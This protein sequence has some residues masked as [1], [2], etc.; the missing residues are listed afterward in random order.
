MS[1]RD[2]FSVRSILYMFVC[3][4]GVGALSGCTA[5]TGQ[6]TRGKKHTLYHLKM[7]QTTGAFVSFQKFRGK[8]VLVDFF[9][10]SC[11]RCEIVVIPMLKKLHTQYEV[12]GLRIV[13]IAIQPQA[14]L[15]LQPFMRVLQIPY[16][17]LLGSLSFAQGHTVFG[18]VNSIPRS[19]L[20]DKCGKIR[21]FFHGQPN[22]KEL[23]QLI[24][25]LLDETP[26]CTS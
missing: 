23:K 18:R 16:P 17:I 22:S 14:K 2:T 8:V 9:A 19:Y 3:M 11:P 6:H 10:T 12:D 5:T 20:F 25:R 4:L 1:V 26:R 7:R 15:F 13:G 21:R 24:K